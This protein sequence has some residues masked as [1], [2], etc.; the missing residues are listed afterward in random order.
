MGNARVAFK[1]KLSDERAMD[2]G[3]KQEGD[4]SAP[5][6][7]SIYFAVML[8]Y[9]FRELRRFNARSKIFQTLVRELLHADDA[10]LV[11]HTERDLQVLMASIAFWLTISLKKKKK[12]RK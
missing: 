4:I 11:A 9:V 1:G 7:F 12:K 5:A 6:V 10:N 2:N 8:S 3:V